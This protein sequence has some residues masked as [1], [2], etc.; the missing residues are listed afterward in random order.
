MSGAHYLG[1]TQGCETQLEI[2]FLCP[3]WGIIHSVVVGITQRLTQTAL[4]LTQWLLWIPLLG[5]NFPG[6]VQGGLVITEGWYAVWSQASYLLC[7][8]LVRVSLLQ[9]IKSCTRPRLLMI[10]SFGLWQRKWSIDR[11]TWDSRE[12]S[13]G[14][15]CSL[16][17][18]RLMNDSWKLVFAR[19]EVNDWTSN[20]PG[21]Y[22][23]PSVY[24]QVP[25][26]RQS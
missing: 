14:W 21:L 25:V 22:S 18:H 5:T 1:R 24:C 20:R 8:L 12:V 11:E 9:R 26:I 2:I 4:C 15:V 6:I 10:L 3:I 7:L 13:A 23:S 17:T 16:E 19:E